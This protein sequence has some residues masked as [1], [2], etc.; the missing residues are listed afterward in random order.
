MLS[1]LSV[2]ESNLLPIQGRN[3]GAAIYTDI[4]I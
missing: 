4:V 3:Y 1:N 2:N